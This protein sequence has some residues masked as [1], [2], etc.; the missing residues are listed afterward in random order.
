[1]DKEQGGFTEGTGAVLRVFI[2]WTII[3]YRL[4]VP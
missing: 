1:M 4:L 2:L 3:V